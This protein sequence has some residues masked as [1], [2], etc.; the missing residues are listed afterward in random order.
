MLIPAAEIATILFPA[1]MIAAGST[2]AVTYTIPNRLI[3]GLVTGF[4][5]LAPFAGFQGDTVA[6]H[7]GLAIV[8][9]AIGFGFFAVGWLGGGDGKLVA[10]TAL[11]VG[12]TAVMD[13][14]LATAVAGGALSV[15]VLL[16]R[17]RPIPV[18]LVTR[19][20]A[21]ELHD[22]NG[23]LPYGVALGVGGLVAYGQ[24]PWVA[25]L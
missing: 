19:N 20:W 4:A 16:Y 21:T 6:I 15:A 18:S 25:A 10:A 22:S 2:D 9:L 11:W 14:V 23:P 8:A 12:P 3:I 7:F 1:A 13:F 24:S 17:A 5:L